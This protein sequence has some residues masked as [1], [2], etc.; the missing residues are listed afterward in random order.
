MVFWTHT[1][2]ERTTGWLNER[3]HGAF[4]EVLIHACARY[5]VACP[6]YTLMPDHWHLVWMGLRDWS[7]QR[8]ATRFLREHLAEKLRPA[9][10]Q[11]RAH[12]HVAREEERKR[13]VFGAMCEY[14]RENPVRAGLVEGWEMWPY[15]GAVVSGYPRLDPRDVSFWEDF[16]KIHARLVEVDA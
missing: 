3:F 4:R 1:I 9:Q 2:E 14:V 8:L 15:S 11:D 13:G 12:D 10:L 7:D 5:E 6:I 16:W